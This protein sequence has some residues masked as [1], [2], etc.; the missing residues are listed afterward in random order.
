MGKAP[1]SVKADDKTKVYGD[2]NPVLTGV[3]TGVKNG[4]Q[5]SAELLDGR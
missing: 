3:L 4:D 2:A 1:L 5:V